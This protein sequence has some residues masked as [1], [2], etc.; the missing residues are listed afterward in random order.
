MGRARMVSG[1]DDG[2]L[3]HQTSLQVLRVGAQIMRGPA[4]CDTIGAHQD[5]L[6]S[7]NEGLGLHD[8]LPVSGTEYNESLHDRRSRRLVEH[9]TNVRDCRST[10]EV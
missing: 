7:T 2:G 1:S 4:P 5:R 6:D 8:E 3:A 9:S 10:S